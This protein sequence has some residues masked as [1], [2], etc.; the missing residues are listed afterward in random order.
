MATWATAADVLEITGE[1]VT[2]EWVKRAN[3]VIESLTGRIAGNTPVEASPKTST[4]DATWLGRAVAYQAVWMPTQPDLFGRMDITQTG[5]STSS[6]SFT[7]TA[8]VLAPFAKLAL[9]RTSWG[10]S[11]TIEVR[12]GMTRPYCDEDDEQDAWGNRWVAM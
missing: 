11:T 5:A 1:T 4:R 8:L 3:F 10:R 2:D 12:N 7:D 6:T 9:A